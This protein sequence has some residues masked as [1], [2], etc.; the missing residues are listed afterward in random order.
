MKKYFIIL[1]GVMFISFILKDNA[2]DKL[3]TKII[4]YFQERPLEKIYVHLD[5]PFYAVGDEIWY[6]AYIQSYQSN[7]PSELSEIFHLELVD[8]TGNTVYKQKRPI[9]DGV[10]NGFVDL[11][12][13]IRAGYYTIRGYTNWN[14]NFSEGLEFRD[15]VKIV[16]LAYSKNEE[17][18]KNASIE[19]F[20]EGGNFVLNKLN[21]IAVKAAGSNYEKAY[22]LN[23]DN[24]T[25]NSINIDKSGFGLLPLV[26]RS[27]EQLSLL[28]D[29][30]GVKYNLPNPKLNGTS[31][32][33]VEKPQAFNLY[34]THSEEFEGEQIVVLVLNDGELVS[35]FESTLKNNGVLIRISKDKLTEGIHQIV[36]LD[37]Q[38]EVLNERVFNNQISSPGNLFLEGDSVYNQRQNVKM[39]IRSKG[40]D[41]V[42]LS[43]SV[44]PVKY[45]GRVSQSMFSDFAKKNGANTS[46]YTLN[47]YLITQKID[48]YDIQEI[49]SGN[50]DEIIYPIEKRNYFQINSEISTKNTLRKNIYAVT[51]KDNSK[52]DFYFVKSESDK[53]SVTIPVFYG[54]R[55]LI[56]VPYGLN[57]SENSKINLEGDELAYNT[58]R[59]FDQTQTE[60]DY[61]R[62]VSE[63]NAIKRLYDFEYYKQI[64]P[65]IDEQAITFSI[66][67]GFHASIK[68]EEYL[69]MES[70]SEVAKELLEGV[71]ISKKE[72]L[73]E[74]R[75]RARDESN[76]FFGKYFD[77]E[78]L[79]F[80]DGMLINDARYI[81][82]LDP[83]NVD[84][85]NM[86]YGTYT[87]NGVEFSGVLSIETVEGNF[88][89]IKQLGQGVFN[90]PG[91]AKDVLF[92]VPDL[93]SNSPD[94]RPILYWNPHI[95]LV[96]NDPYTLSFTTSNE[97][98]EY[99]IDIQGMSHDGIPISEQYT[100]QVQ[101]S[102][103]D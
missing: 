99:V 46:N 103:K 49:V 19:F 39:K 78:P 88:G 83:V 95:E 17:Q 30:T 14:R 53:L 87:L 23:S 101:G 62:Y 50:W 98:G 48:E 8:S 25:I 26:P 92:Q 13:S 27:A 6:S 65:S 86:K 74:I 73:Y 96:N 47:Q 54:M 37:D 5:K 67:T 100:F 21:N 70:M 97:A 85:I 93:D 11:P 42:Y 18:G 3:I 35:V 52:S 68:L 7:S 57:G 69:T 79:M 16:S 12:D 22:L 44:R 20:P 89:W 24:D 60:I 71:R 10:A 38:S 102:K 28:F 63:N 45:F 56:I 81:A 72:E 2:S 31:L 1:V 55:D 15:V 34:I 76:G 51:I 33:L 84:K 9:T 61:A 32:R 91:F 41:K 4:Q 90:Y 29:S 82:E 59:N 43:I 75:M 66:L 58:P 64:K 77:Q 94:F 80:I 40:Y 36:V